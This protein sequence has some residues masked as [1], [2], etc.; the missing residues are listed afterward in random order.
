M[1]TSTIKRVE[2]T[3]RTGGQ[4]TYVIE[5]DRHGRGSIFLDGKLLKHFG[6]RD[7]FGKSRWGSI[8]EQEDAIRYAQ[9]LIEGFRTDEG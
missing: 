2:Y 3:R 8:K 9:A 6:S 7:Y 1:A 4:R 5:A